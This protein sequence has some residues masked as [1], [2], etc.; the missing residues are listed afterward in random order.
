MS[1]LGQDF[2]ILCLF[3]INHY[4]MNVMCGILASHSLNIS[5]R[6]R[7]VISS[8]TKMSFFSRNRRLDVL[9]R[10][11][12]RFAGGRNLLRRPRIGSQVFGRPAGGVVITPDEL[13]RLST[14]FCA[15]VSLV[16]ALRH[17]TISERGPLRP[18]DIL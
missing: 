14:P 13:S 9:R 10:R 18:V 4:T 7:V 12:A 16:I 3:L 15:F 8:Q 2:L 1:N 11:S 5:T 17:L 6:W